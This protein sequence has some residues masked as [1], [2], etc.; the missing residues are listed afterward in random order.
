MAHGI[1]EDRY[2]GS[3]PAWHNI[4]TYPGD[5]FTSA[6]A[7]EATRLNFQVDLVPLF[8]AEGLE[9]N[10]LAT[11]RMDKPTDDPARVLGVVGQSY[12][13][14]QNEKAFGF[15]DAIVGEGAAIYES[16]GVLHGGKEMFIVA[17]L[18][19]RKFWINDDEFDPYI[20]VTNGHTGQHGV[21]VFTTMVRVVCNNTLMMALRNVRKMVTLRHTANVEARLRSVPILLGLADKQFQ[22][23]QA[24]FQTLADTPIEAPPMF[25]AYVDDVFPSAGENPN[26]RTL[27][28]RNSVHSL[29]A[30]PHQGTSGIV[31]TFYA[32]FQAVAQYVDHGITRYE[33]NDQE[34]ERAVQALFGRGQ[35][36]KDR[37]FKLAQTHAAA[38]RS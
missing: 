1:D 12:T 33:G 13:V 22:A 23:A 35:R 19:D 17:R 14:L 29:M 3:Q 34:E 21:R 7:I 20:T 6:E 2:I 24:I 31:N 10:R 25:T 8:T 11:V 15:F 9:I 32:A 5:V 26:S 37:A 36:V 18:Q 4:G 16:M 28:H 38:A 30:H 27:A